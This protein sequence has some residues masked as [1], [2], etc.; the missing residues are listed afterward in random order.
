MGPLYPPLK[1]Y[2]IEKDINKMLLNKNIVLL[3]I[4]Y[5]RSTK[6]KTIKIANSIR[7][8]AIKTSLG[9]VQKILY[10]LCRNNII[11]PKPSMLLKTSASKFVLFSFT[12]VVNSICKLFNKML[13]NLLCHNNMESE[14]YF[15]RNLNSP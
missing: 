8:I 12:K 15:M 7:S 6:Y 4:L 1:K 14:L 10:M 13:Y 5:L 11:F 9:L 3:K 2:I